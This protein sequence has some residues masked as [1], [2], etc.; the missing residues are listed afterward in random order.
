M[1]SLIPG[2]KLR[3]YPGGPVIA[4]LRDGETITVLYRQQIFNGLVWIEVQD[5]NG[6]VGWIPQVYLSIY[7]PVPSGTPTATATP[8]N[9]ITP[10]VIETMMIT[11]TALPTATR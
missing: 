8:T 4:S 5:I 6:R 1:D 10:T 3:Q 9:E 2:L 11:R 7:T